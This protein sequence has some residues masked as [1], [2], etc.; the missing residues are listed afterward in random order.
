LLL[1]IKV[2][3]KEG[4]RFFLLFALGFLLC[5]VFWALAFALGFLVWEV[6]RREKNYWREKMAKEGLIETLH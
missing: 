3:L 1:F 4:L 5:R 2:P 6:F